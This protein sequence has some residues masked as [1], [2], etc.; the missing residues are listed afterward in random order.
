MSTVPQND[1]SKLLAMAD[2]VTLR[3]QVYGQVRR[4]GKADRE[5]GRLNKSITELAK[6]AQDCRKA[7]EGA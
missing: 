3:N 6:S 2:N 5:Y 7:G 1:V 4:T